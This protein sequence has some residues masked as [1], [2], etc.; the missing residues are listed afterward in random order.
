[1]DNF[2]KNDIKKN[3]SGY[4]GGLFNYLM[5]YLTEFVYLYINCIES[6]YVQWKD[7]F[8]V[9]GSCEKIVKSRDDQGG[10]TN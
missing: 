8:V 9:K 6:I 5:N 1:M 2:R 3:L 10:I 4:F 7:F